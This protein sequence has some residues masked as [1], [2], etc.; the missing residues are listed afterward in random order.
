MHNHSCSMALEVKFAKTRPDAV[1]PSKEYENGGFDVYACFDEP[2]MRIEP[3]QTAMIPSGLASAFNPGYVALL[4]E[5]GSTGSKGMGE[6]CGVIDSGYRGEWFIAITNHNTKPLVILKKDAPAP[7]E[8][9]I[10]YP[11]E[12]AVCQV[13]FHKLPDVT[14][15]ELSYE[16]LLAIKSSR[17]TGALGS[18][19]K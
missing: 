17:G 18:S 2:A 11:Y 3:H 5:R 1:I 16:E 8:D 13:I 7:T 4:Y 12:K 15:E 6:R 14:V 19:G 9:V 10:V